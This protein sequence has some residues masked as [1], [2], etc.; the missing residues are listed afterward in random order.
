M[1]L[2]QMEFSFDRAMALETCGGIF[3]RIYDEL[4]ATAAAGHMKAA[5]PMTRFAA[6]LASRQGILKMDP[7]VRTG[8]KNSGDVGVALGT[9]AIAD[10]GCAG[11]L[12]RRS[13]G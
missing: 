8:A 9:G 6:S 2:G 4:A 5:R 3:S 13:E 11:N 12:R 1:M 7:G 10:E